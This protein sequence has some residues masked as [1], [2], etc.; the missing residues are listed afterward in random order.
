MSLSEKIYNLVKESIDSGST[1]GVNVLVLKDGKEVAYTQY[2][3]R[4]LEDKKPIERD[5]IF[6]L[7]SMT[8]PITSAAASLLVARGQ[9]EPSAWLAEYLPEFGEPK[10]LENGKEVPARTPL[11]VSNLLNMTSGISYPADH[12]SG[13]QSGA[14]FDEVISRLYGDNP[15]TTREF[16]KLMG[17]NILAFNPGEHFEYGASADIIGALIEVITGMSFRDFLSENFFEPLGM[18]DTDFFVPAEK[19]DRMGKVYNYDEKGDLIECVTD[20]LGLRYNRDANPT[21]YSGGAGLVSTLD[22]YAK[23]ASMLI[24][25]G[26]YNGKEIMPKAAIRF[27]TK[28]GLTPVQSE[29]LIRGWTWMGGY[30]YG[31]FLRVCEDES[32]LQIM[33]RKGEYGWDGWLGTFFSNEPTTGI[34]FLL[35]TQQ[36]GIGRVGGLTRRIKNLI[37]SELT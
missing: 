13:Q 30:T 11:L 2:G 7:Y 16:S 3:Y 4:D 19:R 33:S 1:A 5:T 34:T 8:K 37:E 6:R 32:K 17:K 10:V 27:M 28:G 24:N 35:G 15:V 20:H 14:V 26:V 9:L 22:D 21:F 12:K 25:D 23:F 36:V 18:K 31:N 29:E